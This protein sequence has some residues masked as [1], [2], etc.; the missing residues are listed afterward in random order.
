MPKPKKG[1][2]FGGSASHQKAIFANLATAL[3]EHGRITTTES[4]AKALRPYAEKLVT[5]AKAGTL[6]HRREVLKVIRNKD[7][8][9][10]LFA[11]IGPFY[12]DRDGGYTR[13]I[14]TV[15][16]KGD[17]APMAI[18]ELVKE[19]TVTSEADRARRVKASQDAPAAAPAEENVVEAV[20]AEATDAEVENA[21]AVVEAIEDETAT[22]ADAPEAE[23]AKKD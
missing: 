1:A 16:R 3:F 14:K 10:T 17:N 2:R 23:E 21:D 11:E 7:V 18:I 6:A 12:A 9:H 20:E 22:A 4:K 5:H 15:P 8:V 13:I 19:K